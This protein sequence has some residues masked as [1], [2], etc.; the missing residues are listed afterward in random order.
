MKKKCAVFHGPGREFEVREFEVAQPAE[1]MVGLKLVSS[2]ICGTDVHIH[3]GYLKMPDFPLVP[4][5]EFIGEVDSVGQ[6]AA[7]DAL[8]NELRLGD[9]GGCMCCNPQAA[10]DFNCLRGETASCLAFGVTY[11]KNVND[12]PHFHGGFAEYPLLSRKESGPASG[13]SGAVCRGGVPLRRTDGD[14]FLRLRRRT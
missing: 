1:N 6:G 7:T 9:R 3:Q 2:G 10:N 13:G 4:G 14:P 12:A 11:V 8:G 5:H